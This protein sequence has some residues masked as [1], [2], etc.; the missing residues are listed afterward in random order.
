[1]ASTDHLIDTLANQGWVVCD[2]TIDAT[3]RHNLYTQSA[4]AWASGNFQQACIGRGASHLLN[5]AIRGDTICWI[6]AA[7][8]SEAGSNFLSWSTSLQHELN[9]QLYAGLNSAEFHFARYQTGQ[10]YKKHLDQHQTQRHR[11]ISL[12]LYLNPQWTD[13]DGGELCLY[14]PED[15]NQ[16]IQRILPQ[17]GRLVLFRSDL[18]PHEVL[19]CSQTRCSLTGW[20]RT[21]MPPSGS[22]MPL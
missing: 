3:L 4:T 5:P 10:G 12:V 14:A 7:T 13:S 2:Q 16:E 1:M 19:P 6:D 15:E 18:F 22:V 8:T 9:R 20:F 21:D 17:P 11:K